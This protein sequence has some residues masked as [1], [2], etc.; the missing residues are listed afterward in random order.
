MEYQRGDGLRSSTDVDRGWRQIARVLE[1]S[2][3]LFLGLCF[4]SRAVLTVSSHVW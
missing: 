4:L 2:R 3:L 1:T